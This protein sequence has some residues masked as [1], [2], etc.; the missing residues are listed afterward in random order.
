MGKCWCACVCVSEYARLACVLLRFRRP[1]SQPEFSQEA[2]DEWCAP[3]EWSAE[4]LA[5]QAASRAAFRAALCPGYVRDLT[6]LDDVEEAVG[7]L[8]VSKPPMPNE[9]QVLSELAAE[10]AGAL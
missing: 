3:V 10:R 2:L 4:Q 7:Q 9:D 8:Y 6:P 1:P 5:R